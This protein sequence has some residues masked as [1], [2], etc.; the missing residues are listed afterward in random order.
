M[1]YALPQR[2]ATNINHLLATQGRTQAE[3]ASHVH[4]TQSM[5]SRRLAGRY[6]WPLRE[7]PLIAEFFGVAVDS[8]LGEPEPQRKS[9][10]HPV[11]PAP[12]RPRRRGKQRAAGPTRRH[13]EEPNPAGAA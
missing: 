3:L 10:Q 2:V 13:T 7:L 1:A 6:A 8:L 5:I 4:V 9:G 12:D 11:S